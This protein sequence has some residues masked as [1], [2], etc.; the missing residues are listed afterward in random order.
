M[1]L[2]FSVKEAEPKKKPKK[3][4]KLRGP[5]LRAILG[6]IA[7][8]QSGWPPR[9]RRYCFVMSR[10]HKLPLIKFQFLTLTA[11][12]HIC[13]FDQTVCTMLGEEV[14]AESHADVCT[15]SVFEP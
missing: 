13:H 8:G 4:S 9:V 2:S 5:C 3:V 15:S 12:N 7:S 6:V 14:Y 11:P 10:D 1:L